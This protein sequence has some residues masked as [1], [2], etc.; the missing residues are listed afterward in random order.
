MKVPNMYFLHRKQT[1]SVV[2]A[3]IL[4]ETTMHCDEF[5]SVQYTQLN[6]VMA[7]DIEQVHV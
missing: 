5:I 6:P 1:N 2:Y 3:A 4:V 7:R